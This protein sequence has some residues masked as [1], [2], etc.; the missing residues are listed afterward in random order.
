M[1]LSRP[2]KTVTIRKASNPSR[3][4]MVSWNS[5]GGRA[6]GKIERIVR[7][8]SIDVPNSSFKVSAEPD[9]PAVLIRVF[10]NDR[11]TSVMVG[12]KMSTLRTV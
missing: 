5:S 3:G 9:D 12:H 8:G 1:F 10:R 2:T 11:P 6:T 4:D 7:E